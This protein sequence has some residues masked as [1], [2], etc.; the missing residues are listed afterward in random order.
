MTIEQAVKTRL[1]SGD[2]ISTWDAFVADVYASIEPLKGMELWNAQTMNPQVTHK[3]QIRFVAGVTSD[4]RIVHRGRYLNITDVTNDEERDE[5]LTF[6]CI[7][8]T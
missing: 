7:E 8:Q 3:V 6:I 1:A 4:M 2:P 5:Y